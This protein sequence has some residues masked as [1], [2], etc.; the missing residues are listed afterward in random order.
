MS[1]VRTTTYRRPREVMHEHRAA[2]REERRIRREV[3]SWVAGAL[4]FLGF[5][6]LAPR[7]TARAGTDSISARDPAIRWQFDT[8]G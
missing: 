4:M 2:E 7:Q 3:M 6:L 8:G 1:R 5:A